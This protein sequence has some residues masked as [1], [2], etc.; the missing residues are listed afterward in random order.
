MVFQLATFGSA[1]FVDEKGFVK[2][3][4][5]MM[6]L[7][8]EDKNLQ[9]DDFLDLIDDINGIE[10]S[11]Y[12]RET[13]FIVYYYDF[14]QGRASESFEG[15]PVKLS[16][17]QDVEL[18]YGTLPE[19]KYQVA[20]DE[21]IAEVLIESKDMLDLGV[22]S[23]EDL[24]GAYIYND[25][26]WEKELKFEIS[27]IVRTESPIVILQDE[28]IYSFLLNEAMSESFARS[29]LNDRIEIVQGRDI[30]NNDEV[31]VSEYSGFNLGDK[32]DFFG[33][34]ILY[35]VVGLFSAADNE[36][37]YN[38]TF[39]LAFADEV[40]IDSTLEK[41]FEWQMYEYFLFY[42]E[43]VEQAKQDFEEKGYE[44]FNSFEKQLIDYNEDVRDQNANRISQI[45]VIIVGIIIYI[46]FMMR[47]SMLNRIREIGVYRSIGATKRDIYKIFFSEIITF[48]TVGSLTSYLL[49]TYIVNE[50]QNQ[51][52]DFTRAF[53]FPFYLFITGIIG[54]YLVN[55]IFGMLPVFTLLRKTPAE[56]IA[57]Y[58][59]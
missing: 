51:I 23:I 6:S 29:T 11:P 5:D 54:I 30:L 58:D 13:E 39:G 12:T 35:E 15:Y 20:I 52:A 16:E 2:T 42:V 9:Y 14:Y 40:F 36:F 47:S 22:D 57:K 21:W 17:Y 24:I 56:I 37:G 4:K 19:F 59:I 25:M 10:F 8:I 44:L 41:V 31:I 34:G 1:T 55:L 3:P 26:K 45:V 27:A 53:Y 48:T 43:D 49:M 32:L 33:D 7:E 28:S 18:V 46:F 38:G 50:I